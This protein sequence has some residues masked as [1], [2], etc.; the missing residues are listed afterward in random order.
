[1]AGTHG[2]SESTSYTRVYDALLDHDHGKGSEVRG[3]DYRDL[4]LILGVAYANIGYRQSYLDLGESAVGAWKRANEQQKESIDRL[5][6]TRQKI[7]NLLQNQKEYN[8]VATFAAAI[9]E[10]LSDDQQ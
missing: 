10:A 3:V 6:A 7:I 5:L 8:F 4:L 9:E 1:M 2:P